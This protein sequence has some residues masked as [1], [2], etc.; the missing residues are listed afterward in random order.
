MS[1][2]NIHSFFIIWLILFSAGF[3]FLSWS[4]FWS[5][6]NAGKWTYGKLPLSGEA[7][8]SPHSIFIPKLNLRT[9]IIF[10]RSEEKEDISQT[11]EQGIV[12][13][14]ET[15]YP[16]EKRNMALVGH[17]SGYFWENSP[18]TEIFS[19]LDKL[20]GGDTIIIF[21]NQKRYSYQVE[22]I[23]VVASKS[24]KVMP[25]ET[26]LTLITCWPPGTTLK[27]LVIKAKLI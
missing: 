14:P 20:T 11:L 4:F 23:K 16:G 5:G 1:I 21:Y 7:V 8:L 6:A 3:I 22:E 24:I 27:R 17:S 19:H 18:Y 9:P 13:W 25:D 15:G 2:R 10:S 26:D 12:H